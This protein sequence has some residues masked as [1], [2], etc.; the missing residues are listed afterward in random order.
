MLTSPPHLS[1]SLSTSIQAI[2][3]AAMEENAEEDVNV[4]VADMTE[5]D[6]QVHNH[7]LL[8]MLLLCRGVGCE[9]TACLPVPSALTY[10]LTGGD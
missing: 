9:L 5:I 1:P 4:E 6:N 10:T 7:T 3:H 2:F 8:R